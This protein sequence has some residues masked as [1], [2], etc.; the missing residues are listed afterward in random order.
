MSSRDKQSGIANFHYCRNPV[1]QKSSKL[2]W[3]KQLNAVL[4]YATFSSIIKT[5]NDDQLPSIS[6]V[7]D[8]RASIL[9][10]YPWWSSHWPWPHQGLHPD[11]RY[12]QCG[13]VGHKPFAFWNGYDGRWALS[14][15]GPIPLIRRFIKSKQDHSEFLDRKM[16][17]LN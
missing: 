7:K 9:S 3:R 15:N 13:I 8:K 17:L 14:H 12:E 5:I 1:M 2:Q 6:S 4:A 16:D 11:E 10:S